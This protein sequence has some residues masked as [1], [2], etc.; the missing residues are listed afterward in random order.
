M[1]HLLQARG[2]LSATGK[3]RAFHEGMAKVVAFHGAVLLAAAL[4]AAFATVWDSHSAGGWKR[5]RAGA[6]C[7][8]LSEVL[9]KTFGGALAAAAEPQPQPLPPAFAPADQP[10]YLSGELVLVDPI[11]R[12]GALRIDGDANGRYQ[13]GPLHY[14]ALLPYGMVRYHGAPAELRD[15]PYGTH[16]HGYFHR[17]PA[18]EENTI[19]PV[20]AEQRRHEIPQNHAISL[21][22]DFSHYSGQGQAWKLVA[23]DT[24]KS[25]LEVEPIGTLVKDGIRDKYTFDI[26][27]VARIWKQRS[28]AELD[29]L[30][31]GLQVQLNLAWAAVGSRDK[32]FSIADL[33]LDDDSR[34]FATELQR[35]RHVRFQQQRWLPARV[36][37]VEHFDYGGGEVTL[38]L[39]G[40][41]DPSLYEDLRATQ[42]TGFWVAAADKTLRTW[43]HR[44]DRKVGKV[45]SWTE[46]PNPPPG[47]SG[48]Q[49][50]LRFAEL[51]EGY[52][53]GRYVRVKSER[54][55]FVTMPPEERIKSPDDLRRAATLTLP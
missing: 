30:Q 52:R 45:Q 49:I 35:R 6:F 32:E 16:L 39:F 47:S 25:K 53:P 34:R 22:D 50:K 23:Y 51:L 17:P 12:R 40:G 5:L 27:G 21:A 18:G 48:I 10:V 8:V 13:D 11:N 9:G 26:D 1:F 7:E 43:F 2:S 3:A 42:S 33:W 38:T 24:K 4:V 46:T 55:A 29:S 28:L 14:F 54:W 41:M 20:P 36:D 44:G 31:P 19:P 15:L 37:H